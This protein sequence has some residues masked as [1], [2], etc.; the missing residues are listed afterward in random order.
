MILTSLLKYVERHRRLLLRVLRGPEEI[1][2][3][4]RQPLQYVA[5]Y[6]ADEVRRRVLPEEL[7]P[8]LSGLEHSGDVLVSCSDVPGA[9][10]DTPNQWKTAADLLA[11]SDRSTAVGILL[12]ECALI[13]HLI[14]GAALW[15]ALDRLPFRGTPDLRLLRRQ[16]QEVPVPLRLEATGLLPRFQ[17]SREVPLDLMESGELISVLEVR[18]GGVLVLRHPEQDLRTELLHEC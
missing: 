4:I 9:L 13:G 3:R 17:T 12:P 16:G 2:S 5:R 6:G 1:H 8:T 14:E 11:P 18:H 7:M 10:P 15:Q